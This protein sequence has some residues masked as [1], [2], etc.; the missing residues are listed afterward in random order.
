MIMIMVIL[1]ATITLTFWHALPRCA[2]NLIL[3]LL[4]LNNAMIQTQSGQIQVMMVVTGTVKEL[5]TALVE[6]MTL[7]T[8]R[9]MICAVP[10]E[11]DLQYLSDSL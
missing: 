3:N 11:V 9:P 8:S 4:S 7:K 10:V 6:I 1:M 5:T 2:L